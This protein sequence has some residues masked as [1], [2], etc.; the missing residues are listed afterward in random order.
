MAQK[1]HYQ[2]E[3]SHKGLNKY[4]IVKAETSRELEQKVN[5]LKKQ[6][7]EEWA[8]KVEREKKLQEETIALEYAQKAT[9]E[10]E[11]KISSLENILNNSLVPKKLCAENLKDFSNFPKKE[12]EKADIKKIPAEPKKNDRAYSHIPF[13][14]K[15]FES[16]KKKRE[17]DNIIK[18][19]KAH[20]DWE[21]KCAQIS[22]ENTEKEIHYKALYDKWKKEE[23]EFYESQSKKNN[24]IDA[25]FEGVKNKE[26]P[27]VEKCAEI[28]LQGIPVP[29][30]YD[31]DI[32]VEY[33]PDS[34]M[35]IIDVTL[36]TMEDLPKLKSV[37]YVKSRKEFKENYLSETAIKKL[38]D[39][40][41]YQMVLQ[42][43]NY[44]F[45]FGKQYSV[46]DVAVINGKIS[47]FD[48]S[49]GKP[50][51]PYIIS[52]TCKKLILNN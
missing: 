15:F 24:E 8:K 3:V 5:A 19:Q 40:T 37:S 36:P 46:F 12:P 30:E 17:E 26:V 51:E 34:D 47:T 44:I 29:L 50:I 7:D 6:W 42:L 16:L 1:Y 20:A 10:A 9:S 11:S 13:F 4:R 38:Y 39:S 35:L 43:L 45:D 52:V 33:N 31:R 14:I 27:C 21:T 25:L 18:F 2:S 41:I 23:T 28:H 48:K 32:I 22:T 49:T